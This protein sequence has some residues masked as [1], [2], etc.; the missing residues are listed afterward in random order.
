MLKSAS[1]GFV[2][3]SLHTRKIDC[4]CNM[5]RNDKRKDCKICSCHYGKFLVAVKRCRGL[6]WSAFNCL[7][8]T[9]GNGARQRLQEA[10]YYGT[11]DCRRV[12]CMILC[13]CLSVCTRQ[14]MVVF[15]HADCYND[16]NTHLQWLKLRRAR[17]VQPPAPI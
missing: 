6:T 15:C 1:V 14:C 2:L 3:L 8:S 9:W 5:S 4:N 10:R 13:R 16:A 17:G 11:A 7:T 12:Q